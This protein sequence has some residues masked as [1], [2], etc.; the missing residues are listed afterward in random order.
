[1]RISGKEASDD[2][3]GWEFVCHWSE[4][5]GKENREV[6]RRLRNGGEGK[7]KRTWDEMVRGAH[8]LYGF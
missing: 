7:T 5:E 1:L 2:D 6:V 4:R 3:N 8:Q